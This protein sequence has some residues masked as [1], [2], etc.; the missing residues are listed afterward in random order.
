MQ[1]PEDV[2]DELAKGDASLLIEIEDR[3]GGYT[4]LR[5][6]AQD[7]RRIIT[8]K[9]PPHGWPVNVIHHHAHEGTETE[10]ALCGDS[11][12]PNRP[13]HDAKD[14]LT[15]AEWD[16]LGQQKAHT[17]IDTPEKLLALCQR[18]MAHRETT[19]VL[20]KSARSV[21]RYARAAALR[22]APQAPN[23]LAAFARPT[24]H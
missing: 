14:K 7:G 20:A 5:L 15:Q 8:V 1:Y 11:H 10:Y 17:P 19:A 4:L 22:A 21:A 12:D 13:R 9:E 2:L 24:G 23:P 3:P 16:E 6:M 18:L